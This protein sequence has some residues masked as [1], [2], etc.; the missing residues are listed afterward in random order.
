MRVHWQKISTA[1]L[2]NSTDGVFPTIKFI[3]PWQIDGGF[4]ILGQNYPLVGRP[5]ISFKILFGVFVFIFVNCVP[6]FC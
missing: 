2:K 1:S 5:C 3:L 6:V 4:G